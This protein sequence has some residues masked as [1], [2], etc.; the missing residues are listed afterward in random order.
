MIS[1][2]RGFLPL[3]WCVIRLE[4]IKGPLYGCYNFLWSTTPTPLP[5][6]KKALHYSVIR[7]ASKEGTASSYW[8][9]VYYLLKTY[10]KNDV[11]AKT[12]ADMTCFMQLSTIWRTECAEAFWNKELLCESIWQI[13][14]QGGV[15]WGITGILQSMRHSMR[16]YWGSKKWA[17]VQDFA[18]YA[19]SLTKLRI[20]SR[21]TNVL[22]HNKNTETWHGNNGRWGTH[23]N[24]IELNTS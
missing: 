10:A 8:E 1:I 23:A 20:G 22:R 9:A 21:N 3:T 4:Y 11:N 7:Q 24:N 15:Y 19:T 13:S 17:I 2:I 5:C 14:P 12:D 16:S 6:L 18:R